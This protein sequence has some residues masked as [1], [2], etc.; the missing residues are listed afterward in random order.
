MACRIDT[1]PGRAFVISRVIGMIERL[2]FLRQI[3]P[4]VARAAFAAEGAPV[5]SLIR[6]GDRVINCGDDQGQV[7]SEDWPLYG[8]QH[9]NCQT[10]AI[11]VLLLGKGSVACNKDLNPVFFGGP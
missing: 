3:Y 11:K 10:P 1:L 8:G 6:T 5:Y 2:P 7:L 9:H 4:C